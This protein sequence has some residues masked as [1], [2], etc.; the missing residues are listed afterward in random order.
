MNVPEWIY[1]E[2]LRIFDE[3]SLLGQVSWVGVL[4]A[5]S[6]VFFAV[7]F[8]GLDLQGYLWIVS[9]GASVVTVGGLVVAVLVF[10]DNSA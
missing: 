1:N 7:V 3:H 2:T 9:I 8:S 6:I 5:A 4:L 10:G